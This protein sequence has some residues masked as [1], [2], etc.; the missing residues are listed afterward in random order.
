MQPWKDLEEGLTMSSIQYG[1]PSE[2]QEVDYA[3]L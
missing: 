2:L 1:V 3:Y